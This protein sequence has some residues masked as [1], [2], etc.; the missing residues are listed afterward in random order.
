MAFFYLSYPPVFWDYIK[1]FLGY[2][3]SNSKIC[4][5]LSCICSLVSYKNETAE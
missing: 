2:M 4:A 5:Q 1:N 3:K